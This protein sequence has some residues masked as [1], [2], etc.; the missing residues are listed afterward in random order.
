MTAVIAAD[1]MARASDL[2]PR[3][4]SPTP[5]PVSTSLAARVSLVAAIAAEH[6]VAVDHEGRFPVEAVDAMRAHGL[7][8]GMVPAELGGPGHSFREIATACCTLGRACSSAAMVFAMHQIQVACLVAHH[9]NGIWA[10]GFLARVVEEQLLLA[11]VTSEAGVGGEVRRSKCA[12]VLDGE[13]IHLTKIAPSISYGRYAD[14]LLITARRNAEAES[15]DQVLLVATKDDCHLDQ[16][17]V[18]NAMGMRGTS[19]ESF[20]VEADAHAQQL[21]ATPFSVIASDTML[22]VSHLLWSSLWVGIAADALGRTRSFLRKQKGDDA[23]SISVSRFA[24]AVERL[25]L[26]QA[27]VQRV[28]DGFT[29]GV[30]ADS[31][32]PLIRTADVNALKSSVSETC[33]DVAQMCLSVNGFA[34][35]RNDSVFSVSRHLRDLH[36][37]VLMVHN[38]RVRDGTGRLLLARMPELGVI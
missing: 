36:S 11:S 5:L 31:A 9:A 35:Y 22:P 37:A 1:T 25:Q 17:G 12:V 29:L 28:L 26:A 13:R 23:A 15:S 10:R 4:T 3:A 18:W 2:Q 16:T 34:G 24:E 30:T 8:G 38:D 32:L 14:A 20:M 6:A 7:L 21:L 19:T 33:L 27:R